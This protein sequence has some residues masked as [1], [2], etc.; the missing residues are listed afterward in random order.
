LPWEGDVDGQ[1]NIEQLKRGH[2]AF[3]TQD[4]E[5]LADV[6]AADSVW[7]V[8]GRGPHSGNYQGR[9]AVFGFFQKLGELSGGTGQLKPHDYTSSDDHVVA[10]TTFTSTRNG[11]TLA[12]NLC[13]VG[14]WRDGQLVENW[15]IFE[16]P[17]A[18]DE[19]FS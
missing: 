12:S 5:T 13:E 3:S 9:D 1:S 11:K 8:T 16:D 7:H 17:Y 18:A 2:A 6:I 15:I 4:M 14:H 19:H 10:L